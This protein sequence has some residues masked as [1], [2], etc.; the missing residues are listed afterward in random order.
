MTP[1]K[2][3]HLLITLAGASL[4]AALL[5]ADSVT[6]AALAQ[7]TTAACATSP[8]A[9]AQARYVAPRTMRAGAARPTTMP[10][11]SPFRELQMNLCN[12]GQASCYR[13]GKSISEAKAVILRTAPDLVTVNEV[14]QPDVGALMSVM[15]SMYPGDG[16][17]SVFWPAWQRSTNAAYPC[18]DGRGGYGIGLIGHVPAA[19]WHGF[20]YAGGIYPDQDTSGE[21]RAWTC[22]YAIGNYYGCTTHL[23]DSD[24]PVALAQCTY[25]M[26]TAVPRMWTQNGSHP[27]VVGGD[28][29]LTHGGSPDVQD[30]V[31]AHWFRKGDGAL[32]HVLATDDLTFVSSEKI[33]MT[34]TDHPAWLV[35]LSF[36]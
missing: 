7:H 2:I 30:C 4:L 25:L 16:V 29:N 27:T 28:L 8:Q 19:Q 20:T 32:Q 10:S 22:A 12:S 6:T 26:N 14:C 18:T 23:A 34:Y 1:L 11:G 3:R 35:S 33:H 36:P 9:C 17:F 24:G 15:E 13:G 21:E 5:P 31:P